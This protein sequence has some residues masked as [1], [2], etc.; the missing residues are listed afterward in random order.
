MEAAVQP[1]LAEGVMSSL[2]ELSR[3]LHEASTRGA[4]IPWTVRE[5]VLCCMTRLL[6]ASRDAREQFGDEEASQ[7]VSGLQVRV[8]GAVQKHA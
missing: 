4:Q 1:W 8:F 5:S 7:R 6:G 3:G 2:V